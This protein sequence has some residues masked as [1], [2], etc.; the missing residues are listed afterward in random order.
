MPQPVG[1]LDTMN[2]NYIFQTR[3]HPRRNWKSAAL[4]S[5][6]KTEVRMIWPDVLIDATALTSLRLL[7]QTAFVTYIILL[8]EV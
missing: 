8:L 2:K 3:S 7:R 6:F 5:T 1:L 4:G